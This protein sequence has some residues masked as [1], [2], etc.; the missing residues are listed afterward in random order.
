M[1]KSITPVQSAPIDLGAYDNATN[2][3]RQL[4]SDLQRQCLEISAEMPPLHVE[5]VKDAHSAVKL[6]DVA[7]KHNIHRT[8][9][10]RA[11]SS[12]KAQQLMALLTATSVLVSGM[13]NANIQYELWRIFQDNRDDD[14]RTAIA[15]ISEINRMRQ[16]DELMASRTRGGDAL[17]NIVINSEL[18][19]RTVLDM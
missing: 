1:V 8:T 12:P 19:P 5:I 18:L 4:E 6:A 7:K 15:A 17:V 11:L 3:F 16:H 10:T 14:P 9:V 13:T 2:E